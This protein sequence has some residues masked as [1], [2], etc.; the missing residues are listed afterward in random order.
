M[1]SQ[2]WA[3]FTLQKEK[4]DLPTKTAENVKK[5]L[6]ELFGYFYKIK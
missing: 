1:I 4:H 5:V 2:I 6:R 3:K